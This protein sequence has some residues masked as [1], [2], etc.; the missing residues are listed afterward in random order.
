M[1]GYKWLPPQGGTR[2]AAYKPIHHRVFVTQ[3]SRFS[4][5]DLGNTRPLIAK[6]FAPRS[7]SLQLPAC[8]TRRSPNGLTCRGWS[9]R[10]GANDSI[11]NGWMVWMTD[12]GRGRH[13]RSF[14]PLRALCKSRLSPANFLSDWGSP[15]L[16]SVNADIA[17][18][19][20]LRG[21]VVFDKRQDRLA[22]SPTVMPIKPWMH[23]SW[24]FPR[25]PL[26][27]RKGGSCPGPVF[28]IVRRNPF[29]TK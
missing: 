1:S 23:R 22:L 24:L 2:N 27:G 4:L 29:G 20:V 21:I 7:F 6:W 17:C 5:K 18:E 13:R 25:D 12:P 26:F 16:I 3:R 14:F 11:T 19:A 9:S 8:K 10:S 28:P 15:F